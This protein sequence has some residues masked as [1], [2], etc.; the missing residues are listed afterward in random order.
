MSDFDFDLGGLNSL[1]EEFDDEIKDWSGGASAYVGT[2]VEYAV[3]LEYGTSKMD[4]KPFFRPALN[5]ARGDLGAFLR[6]N[7]QTAVENIDSA[8]ELVRTLALALERRV[9]EIITEKGLIDTGTLR[10]SVVA[11]PS[12]PDTLPAA[13]DLPDG[14][15]IPATAGRDA[16]SERIQI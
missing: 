5:E 7:T 3:Y 11:V 1:R 14:D 12:S 6:D 2:A 4:P 13:E 15:G 9:K 16:V 8:S 10:A